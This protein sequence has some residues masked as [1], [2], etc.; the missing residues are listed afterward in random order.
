MTTLHEI[1]GKARAALL[2]ALGPVD[3][4]RFFQQYSNGSGDYTKERQQRPQESVQAIHER[5]MSLQEAGLLPVPPNAKILK[6]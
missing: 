2:T 4:A 6:L 5:T 3:Y 1:N